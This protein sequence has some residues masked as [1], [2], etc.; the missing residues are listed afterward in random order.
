M[1]SPPARSFLVRISV[2]SRAEEILAFHNEHMTEHLWPRTL[3]QFKELAEQGCLYE[4]LETTGGAEE[5]VGLCYIAHGAEPTSPKT[6]RAEFGGVYITDECRGCGIATALGK[7]AI[8]NH[9]VWDPPK[10]RMIAHV[11]EY[12]PLPRG[13]LE[14]QLGFIR[15]GE[16]TPPAEVVPASM[17]RNAEGKVVGHLF[18]FQKTTLLKFAAWIERFSGTLESKAGISNLR[19]ALPSM[20]QYKADTIAALRDLGRQT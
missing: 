16:E 4:A 10:G 2:E 11:H 3:E 8:S 1:I 15:N 19:I 7:V 5:M 13:L 20:T 9:F 14:K 17:K 6:E 18:E 12:N